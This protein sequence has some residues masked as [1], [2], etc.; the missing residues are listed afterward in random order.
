MKIFTFN[1]SN[2]LIIG[3]NLFNHI[4]VY[5]FNQSNFS[6]KIKNHWTHIIIMLC[7]FNIVLTC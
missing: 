5:N 2:F 4:K 3:K 7:R 1:Q 6:I